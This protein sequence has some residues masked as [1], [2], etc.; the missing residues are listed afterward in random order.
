MFKKKYLISLVLILVFNAS[1]IYFL[2]D[3]SNT[4][5][6]QN[7]SQDEATEYLN[8]LTNKY[9]VDEVYAKVNEI[10]DKKEQDDKNQSK[11]LR[12]RFKNA[13]ILGDS[14]AE[15]LIDYQILNSDC[16]IAKRGA[17]I[18][19]MDEYVN[20]IKNRQPDVIFLEY[21]MNDL[22]YNRGN[23]ERFIYVYRSQLKYL[24]E[25]F[26]DIKIYVN[27]ILPIEQH[28]INAKPVYAT[29]VDFNNALKQLCDEFSIPFINN[30]F[31]LD[32]MSKKYVSDGIHPEFPYYEKWAKNMADVAGL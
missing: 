11:G 15:G 17:R 21:G 24:T 16:I 25:N 22:E 19:T 20:E 29:H 30:E 1:F 13:L 7:P 3:Q 27:G 18:D 32:S 2:N 12:K 28:A 5:T 6:K 31:I 9:S 14:I 10:K 8:Q 4:T 26:P 23:A